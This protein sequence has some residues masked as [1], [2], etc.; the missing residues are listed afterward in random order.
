MN[1]KKILLVDDEII[2]RN[3]LTDMLTLNNYSILTAAN[4]EEA[5]AILE[6]WIP[7][8]II[9]DIM[10]P[11]MDGYTFYEKIKDFVV[12]NQIPFVFFSAKNDKEA[13]DKFIQKGVELFISKPFKLEDLMLLIDMKIKKLNT[14]KK[15]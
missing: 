5:L 15:H 10:M 6:D 1:K 12:L 2:L 9:S 13:N 8:I 14:N 3:T 7:D 11:V 4:G